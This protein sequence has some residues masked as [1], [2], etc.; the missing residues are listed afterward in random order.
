MIE[1][2]IILGAPVAV[3]KSVKKKAT[4]F[5]RSGLR[6][7]PEKLQPFFQDRGGFEAYRTAR[8]DAD[9]G[10]SLWIYAFTGFA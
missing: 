10:A 9:C 3:I 1:Y 8:L 4:R 2:S 5:F 6:R 7:T